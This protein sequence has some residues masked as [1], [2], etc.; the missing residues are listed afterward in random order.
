MDGVIEVHKNLLSSLETA[1][2]ASLPEQRVGRVFL[3]T[4]A[5]LKS[6]H[7]AYCSSHPRAVCILNKHK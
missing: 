6:V 2:S 3:Q 4:A 7:I 1:S 5:N